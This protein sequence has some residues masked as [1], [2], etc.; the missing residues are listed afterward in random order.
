MEFQS[1]TEGWN[2]W[3]AYVCCT[4]FEVRKRYANKG[5][6][7][8]KIRSCR[9]VCL[10]EGHQKQDKRDHRNV[11]SW[12]QCCLLINNKPDI[13]IKEVLNQFNASGSTSGDPCAT[14]SDIKWSDLL[15]NARLKKKTLRTKS[16]LRPRT[17]L[18]KKEKRRIR[19]QK[20]KQRY[21]VNSY[22]IFLSQ[23]THAFFWFPF[24]IV[25][26]V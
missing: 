12:S 19:T 4:S 11:A 21:V 13:L 20:K 17:W 24:F 26:R 9:F 18:D 1:E 25:A 5:K 8:G 22:T 16:S 10:K 23:F 6:Y 3:N 7:D 2:F 15:K 14:Y